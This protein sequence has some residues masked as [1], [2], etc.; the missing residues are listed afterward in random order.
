MLRAEFGIPHGTVPHRAIPTTTA[1]N[2]R[3]L[4]HPPLQG[5]RLMR[6]RWFYTAHNEETSMMYIKNK[7]AGGAKAGACAW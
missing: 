5:N 6:V 1:H 2:N 7:K 4:H 3:P